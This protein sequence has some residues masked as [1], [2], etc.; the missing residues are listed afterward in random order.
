MRACLPTGGLWIREVAFQVVSI[1]DAAEPRAQSYWAQVRLRRSGD[2]QFSPA[3]KRVHSCPGDPRLPTR[4]A[5][6]GPTWRRRKERQ[7]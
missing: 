7:C 6:P 2:L 1:G 3:K 5:V 4:V